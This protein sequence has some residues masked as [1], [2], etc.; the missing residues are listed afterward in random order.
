MNALHPLRWLLILVGFVSSMVACSGNGDATP[1]A[2]DFELV[3]DININGPAEVAASIDTLTFIVD[4]PQGLY[5]PG[6]ESK[7][8]NVEIKDMDGDPSDLELVATVPITPARL[9]LV[10]IER[11]GLRDVSLDVLV[12]GT[13][14][15]DNP[16]THIAEGRVQGI[17]FQADQIQT[18]PLSFNIRPDRLPPRVTEVQPADGTNI[19]S[20]KVDTIV[21]VF[22]KPMNAASVK[23][24]GNFVVKEDASPQS[25]VLDSSGFIATYLVGS[26]KS[27]TTPFSFHLEI[28]TDVMSEDFVRLDQVGGDPGAQPYASTFTLQC[29]PTQPALG[30][31]L[32]GSGDVQQGNCPDPYRFTCVQGA[33]VPTACTSSICVPGYVCDSATLHCE[34]DCRRYGDIDVC[35]ADRSA[36]DSATGACVSA[37]L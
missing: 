3:P 25:I 13:N 4:S 16:V 7:D 14:N 35:P 8:G 34:V 10:R 9:P 19:K 32:C 18:I 31:A 6:S 28:S 21:V 24:P 37:A 2:L 27:D 33:C 11:G 36:C 26:L 12:I 5:P 30:E 15:K 22:S 1:T 20:C 17:R 23:A 29:D